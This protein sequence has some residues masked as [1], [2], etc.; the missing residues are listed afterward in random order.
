M[1]VAEVVVANG[2]VQGVSHG[3]HFI[4]FHC[5]QPL[6]SQFLADGGSDIFDPLRFFFGFFFRIAAGDQI[7]QIRR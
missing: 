5:D 3:F 1:Q 4:F 2:I 6:G 7:L